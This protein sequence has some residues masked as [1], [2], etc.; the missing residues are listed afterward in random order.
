MASIHLLCI[1]GSVATHRASFGQ[2]TGSILKYFGCSGYE[3]K[4]FDCY[5]QVGGCGHYEDAGVKC[6][7]RTGDVHVVS[8]TWMHF[9]ICMQFLK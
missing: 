1:A 5:Y 3:E 8:Y 4:L 6:H 7:M 2:G 9:D